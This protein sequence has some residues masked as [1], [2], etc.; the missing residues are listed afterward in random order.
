MLNSRAGAQVRGHAVSP[1][2]SHAG[3]AGGLE[4]AWFSSSSVQPHERSRYPR[5]RPERRHPPRRNARQPERRQPFPRPQP[6]TRRQRLR[7]PHAILLH[8]RRRTK[9]W[10]A[11]TRLPSSLW[12]SPRQGPISSDRRS[13]R[14]L[15]CRERLPN[16]QSRC[17]PD[18]TPEL[19]ALTL[20]GIASQL[21]ASD[22]AQALGYATGIAMATTC[23]TASS[24]RV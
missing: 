11:Q 3:R 13:V 1:S 15:G 22:E 21:G 8:R 12:N 17:E 5:P 23:T 18:A 19:L 24:T 4:L 16:R 6:S 14:S 10:L 7:P 9:H 20:G 2:T